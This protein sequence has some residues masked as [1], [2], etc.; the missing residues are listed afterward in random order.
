[1]ALETQPPQE[2]QQPLDQKKLINR[3]YK[4]A[5]QSSELRELVDIEREANP[6]SE[7]PHH[8]QWQKTCTQRNQ[9]A[10]QVKTLLSQ[11]QVKRA[12][13]E[14]SLY[15]L[16]LHAQKHE[17]IL[18]IQQ[19]KALNLQE[20]LK[21]NLE[22]LLYKLFPDGPHSKTAQHYRFRSKGSLSIAHSGEFYDFENKEG[23]G[24]LQLIAKEL[25]LDKQEAK[26]WAK[27]FLGIANDIKTPLTFKRPNKTIPEE[28]SWTSLQPDPK[29][30]PPPR[31]KISKLHHYYKEI[32]RHTYHDHNG[33]LLYYVLR[34][35]GDQNKKITPPLSYG[36]YEN[37]EPSW[38][39]KG[40]NPP[41][42]KRPLYNLHLLKEKPLA[43]ILIVEG[44]KAADKAPEKFPHLICLTWSGGASSVTKTDWSPLHGKKV[45]IW[46]D[47]DTAGFKAAQDIIDELKKIGVETIILPETENLFKNLPPKWDL[48]DPLPQ[49]ISTHSLT[50]NQQ[51]KN[52]FQTSILKN[53]KLDHPSL[54]KTKAIHLLYAYEKTHQQRLQQEFPQEISPHQRDTIQYR[55]QHEGIQFLQKEQEI[56]Q[57]VTTD[58]HINASGE[59]A[60]RLTYQLHLFE[61][62]TGQKPTLDQTLTLKQAL[63]NFP[64]QTIT[65]PPETKEILLYQV[66]SIY[67]ENALTRKKLDP[68]E[69]EHITLQ[70]QRQL[71]QQKE[72]Q[73]AQELAIEKHKALEYTK[74]PELSP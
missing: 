20:Q 66:L 38:Q 63:E 67:S 60:Q 68:K 51:N 37:Q 30:P 3:Y 19:Q 10:Y 15:Y 48:A 5:T 41:G 32:A 71:S 17:E 53:L 2:N 50:F 12:F 6:T 9:A 62:R 16:E 46:P 47:N 39:L 35:Q 57:S 74:G 13:K 4:Y 44:E 55:Q 29:I 27:Q 18:N 65:G 52:H 14:K 72:L 22:S 59:L 7:S 36:K 26:D 69:L 56:L 49:G 45:K 24:L 23:G 34:L 8:K 70:N 28:S 33:N 43:E 42:E 11:D 31:E 58:P 61:A 21:N 64:Y 73:K 54:E 40:Y 25:Q 1:M